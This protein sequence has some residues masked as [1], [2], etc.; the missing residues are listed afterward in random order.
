MQAFLDEWK[1]DTELNELFHDL[2]ESHNN[3]I[4]STS[5]Y[6]ILKKFTEK[7]VLLLR[8]FI[9]EIISIMEKN[10]VKQYQ[11]PKHLSMDLLDKVFEDNNLLLIDGASDSISVIPWGISSGE[12]TIKTKVNYSRNT[13]MI[14]VEG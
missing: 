12:N 11:I 7:L 3:P 5:L 10:H 4:V 14:E 2:I 6:L 13:G 8:E 9:Y 1:V